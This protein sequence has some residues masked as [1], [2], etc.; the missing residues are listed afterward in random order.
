MR[1]ISVCWAFSF[2]PLGEGSAQKRSGIDNTNM[3][4]L[5]VFLIGVLAFS[6]NVLAG[7]GYIRGQIESVALFNEG[8]P[9]SGH[10]TGNMEI[11]VKNGFSLP[12]GVSCDRKIVTTLKTSDP[13][14]AMLNLL[15][16]ARNTKRTVLMVITDNPTYTA[17]PGRCS[18]LSVTE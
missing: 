9:D 7:S 11:Q 5:F 2:I 1:C 10:Q 6:Q 8:F 16:D 13:D 15:R 14:R 4:K 3:K 12:A 18:L 17:Y